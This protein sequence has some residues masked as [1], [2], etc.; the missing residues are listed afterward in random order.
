MKKVYALFIVAVLMGCLGQQAEKKV[1][2]QTE[3]K[4]LEGKIVQKGSDT[5]IITAQKWAEVFMTENPKGMD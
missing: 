4:V 2:Q 3:K 5:M 1:A